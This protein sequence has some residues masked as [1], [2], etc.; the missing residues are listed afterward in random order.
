MMHVFFLT[1]AM[2]A[3]VALALNERDVS[4]F[5][6]SDAILKS[7]IWFQ[8][9]YVNEYDET[10][11]KGGQFVIYRINRVSLDAKAG[12]AEEYVLPLVEYLSAVVPRQQ[13][14]ARSECMGSCG[15]ECHFRPESDECG[16]C[17]EFCSYLTNMK[18]NGYVDAAEFSTCKLIDESG[19]LYAGPMCSDSG[20]QIKIGVF[21][22]PQCLVPDRTK[23]IDDYLKDDDGKRLKL[24]YNLLEQVYKND[25]PTYITNFQDRGI[26]CEDPILC[27][28]LFYNPARCETRY[29]PTLPTMTEEQER[30]QKEI[31][32]I[33]ETA[34]NGELPSPEE[35][36]KDEETTNDLVGMGFKIETY[37]YTS[38]LNDLPSESFRIARPSSSI[39]LYLREVSVFFESCKV[40]QDFDKTNTKDAIFNQDFD[41]TNTKDGQYVIFNVCRTSH[42]DDPKFGCRDE[43]CMKKNIVPLEDYLSAVVLHQVATEAL[44]CSECS[45]CRYHSQE[46]FVFTEFCS[47]CSKICSDFGG[48]EDANADED[49]LSW[50]LKGR[51]DIGYVDAIKFSRCQMIDGESSMPLFAGPVCSGDNGSAIAIGVFKDSECTIPD[52]TK[53]VDD[54]LK[55]GLKMSYDMLERIYENQNGNFHIFEQERSHRGVSCMSTYTFDV[56]DACTTLSNKFIP[57]KGLDVCAGEEKESRAYDKKSDLSIERRQSQKK[58]EIVP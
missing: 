43:K 21:E 9:C 34:K 24:S 33:I 26:Y 25:I 55:D 45:W 29:G 27:G 12:I 2:A 52:P 11:P 10:R 42:N 3:T 50:Y 31:C 51:E 39:P 23:Q 56:N 46:G 1:L 38:L 8:T 44:F 58:E 6:D 30:N 22:D 18:N 16:Y 35:T 48:W 5:L 47:S 15:Y 14:I 19:P 20:E 13:E 37:T 17:S 53:K 4:D 28:F 7:R 57:C 41:K 32:A 40:I 36:A 49:N 54:Y